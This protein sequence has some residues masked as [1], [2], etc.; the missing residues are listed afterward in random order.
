VPETIAGRDHDAPCWWSAPASGA[1]CQCR[2]YCQ[3]G[4]ETEL[5]NQ[6]TIMVQGVLRNS[7]TMSGWKTPR[8]VH[9]GEGKGLI[10]TAEKFR[11]QEACVV[12]GLVVSVST[13]PDKS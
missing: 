10:Y 5:E 4:A 11:K 2:V 9:S 6:R 13:V 7:A 3:A 8:R 12:K 1:A